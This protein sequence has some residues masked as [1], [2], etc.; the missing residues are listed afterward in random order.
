MLSRISTFALSR[1]RRRRN[2]AA[3]RE[4]HAAPA[5]MPSTMENGIRTSVPAEIP[6]PSASPVKA[7][8]RTITNTS[9]TEAPAMIICGMP[10][11]V[12]LPSSIRRSI[13]GTITAGDTAAT[14]QP[15][16]AASNTEMPSRRGASS[17]IPAISKQAG[18]KQSSTAGR[19]ARFRSASSRFRP[20]RVRMM[21]SAMRRRSAEMA[22]MLPSSTSSA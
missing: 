4:P 1:R 17:T 21:M 13:L 10:A 22:R 15:M 6:P 2:T 12:P 11:R 3:S 14:T 5:R 18:T 9:S 7:V 8:K 16:M 19:P 20:A